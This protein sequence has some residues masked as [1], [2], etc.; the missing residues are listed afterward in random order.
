[1]RRRTSP[2]AWH[3]VVPGTLSRPP[4]G[5]G[6]PQNKGYAF[7]VPLAAGSLQI[8]YLDKNLK[9][10]QGGS[11][12]LHRSEGNADHLFVFQRDVDKRAS[13][14]SRRS[15]AT[16]RTPPRWST[17]I[18]GSNRGGPERVPAGNRTVCWA[19]SVSA[20]KSPT[21]SSPT[22]EAS[23][24]L[25]KV[26]MVI[27][28]CSSSA[29]RRQSTHRCMSRATEPVSEAPR[30][31]RSPTR[32]T[33]DPCM[34]VPTD[35]NDSLR[36]RQACHD[37]QVQPASVSSIRVPGH[38]DRYSKS[39]RVRSRFPAHSNQ[40]STTLN[41]A[42]HSHAILTRPEHVAETLISVTAD[43]RRR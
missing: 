37:S 42:Q 20:T 36:G 26:R 43:C 9:V 6:R 28:P 31:G 17:P 2:Q 18:A 24:R 34:A 30:A 22:Q 5:C 10:D 38:I 27:R 21:D 39:P 16:T 12:P 13:D 33:R 40:P 19:C 3:R 4:R 7:T 25:E 35:T 1:M 32:T 29:R 23:L 8:D 15:P 41:T 11:I 14:C